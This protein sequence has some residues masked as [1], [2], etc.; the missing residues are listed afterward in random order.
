MDIRM[1]PVASL[2]PYPQ[3]TKRHTAKQVAQIAASITR[4]GWSQPIAV[5]SAGVVI[6]GHGRLE[7]AKSMGLAEVPTVVMEGLT[8]DEAKALRIADNKLNES[9]WEKPVVMAELKL[10]TPELVAVTGFPPIYGNE[11]DDDVV[12]A[13][14]KKPKSKVGDIYVLGQH[15]IACGDSTDPE[16]LASLMGGG[17][18]DMVF[19]DPPYGVDYSGSGKNS[20][21][22]I[23]NDNLG[24]D[25]F[26]K[27][28]TGAFRA[29][30]ANTKSTAG[31][32]VFHDPSTQ[33]KFEASLAAAGL[34]I[35]YQLIWNKPSAGL[36][37]NEYRK[38]HEPFFYCGAKGQRP[39][40]YGDRC[41]TTVVKWPD[42]DQEMLE[43]VQAMS[44]AE[45]E[46]KTTIWSEGRE[47][48]N[49]YVHPTQK[50]VGLIV[51]ALANSSV[52]GDTVLDSF[53]GSGAT[54]IACQ[55]TGRR[56]RGVELDPAYVDAI[57]Q[58]WV[59]YTGTESVTINGKTKV[60]PKS[61]PSA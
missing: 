47:N 33:S 38:K 53:S 43:Y 61:S 54:L 56:F 10:L 5:D 8:E 40:F 16:V 17:V 19:T 57:V 21:N 11:A 26:A 30:F 29:A 22:R 1:T 24:D 45:K 58:R 41:N 7:A 59:D 27:L 13:I 46:G 4:F 15:A 23:M 28:L 48:V 42:G 14:P 51:R 55:K 39:A 2:K 3:N 60:W 32:Y 12:P 37:M 31:W 49:S 20:S 36:G 35:R 6:I 52:A 25:E 9:P 44:R 34:E 50:P 18:A